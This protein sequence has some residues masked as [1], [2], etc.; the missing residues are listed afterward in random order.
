MDVAVGKGVAVG[1][2]VAVGAGTGVAVGA[3]G[4]VAVGSGMRVAVG[5]GRG[6][7]VLRGTR[8]DNGSGVL[9]VLE[10]QAVKTKTNAITAT[11]ALTGFIL[12]TPTRPNITTLKK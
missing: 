3:G 10:A 4:G 9:G 1:T 2:G 6:V 5:S 12:Q 8:V 11:I 7:N